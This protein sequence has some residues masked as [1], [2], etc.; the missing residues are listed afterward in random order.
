MSYGS[1]IFESGIS[2]HRCVSV[3]IHH[4]YTIIAFDEKLL[5]AFEEVLFK[6]SLVDLTKLITLHPT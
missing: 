1:A 2:A 6:K 3:I 4:L 5:T